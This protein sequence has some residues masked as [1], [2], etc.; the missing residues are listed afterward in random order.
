MHVSSHTSRL[1]SSS[2]WTWSGI[3]SYSSGIYKLLQKTK[4]AAA[5]GQVER[6]Q[7]QNEMEE[8]PGVALAGIWLVL[9]WGPGFLVATASQ[10]NGYVWDISNVMILCAFDPEDMSALA[11]NKEEGLGWGLRWYKL[12]SIQT[13]DD[14][15]C[16][17]VR[18]RFHY[19]G[20]HLGLMGDRT[21]Y[22]TKVNTAKNMT[23]SSTALGLSDIC[24]VSEG[25]R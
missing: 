21:V 5:S 10:F 2:L 24:F 6:T 17:F 1:L 14:V 12:T 3:P 7:V 22:S 8:K 18:S 4:T 9:I 13:V 15:I 20:G 23:G 25:S 19:A 16:P 11:D